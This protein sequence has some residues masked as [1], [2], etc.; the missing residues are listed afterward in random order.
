MLSY[1]KIMLAAFMYTSATEACYS[2]N[3]AS[4]ASDFILSTV[5]VHFSP[6]VALQDGAF[7]IHDVTFV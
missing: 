4:H 1:D 3:V 5:S 2:Y 7:S 6:A